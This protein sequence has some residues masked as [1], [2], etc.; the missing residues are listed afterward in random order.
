MPDLMMSKRSKRVVWLWGS[1]FVSLHGYT[2]VVDGEDGGG[3]WWWVFGDPAHKVLSSGFCKSTL[4]AKRAA[5]KCVRG[6][7][8]RE[9]TT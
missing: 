8:A 1:C 3:V 5:L 6:L 4:A 2:I 9:V 7:P